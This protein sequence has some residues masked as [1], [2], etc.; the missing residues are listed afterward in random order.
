MT[1]ETEN[2]HYKQL[3]LYKASILIWKIVPPI[4]ILLGTIGNSLSILVLTRRS[5][6]VSST[7]LFLTVLAC[8]DL[9]VLYSGL[10]R[11]WLIYLFDTD[12][13]NLSEAGCKINVW[14][15]YSSLDFSAWILIV[16][17]LE[18]VVSTWMPHRARTLCTKKTAFAFII[19]VGV[20]ILGINSHILYGIGYKITQD[21][22]YYPIE[23]KCIEID[24]NYA[25]FFENV[26]PWIDLCVYCAVPFVV[27]VIGNALILF[28]VLNS[29]KKSK[30]TIASRLAKKSSMPAM[31]FTLNIVFLLSTLPV[32][33]YTIGQAY[34]PKDLD[35]YKMAKLDFW[36]AVVNMLMYTNN[37]LNF[38]LYCLS[39]TKFR[40][41]VIRL[42]TWK[43]CFR[44][45]H[46]N[47]AQ[48]NY[49]STRFDN[50]SRSSTA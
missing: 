31:L 50:Q 9:L 41:E 12:V 19:A 16:L 21:E 27:I 35:D 48:R 40:R 15:V 39:G 3:G 44:L 38:L 43:K 10:L 6:R 34:W 11:Q 23:N 37:S 46:I 29:Q 49:T 2:D 36:W 4:L 32:S 26:W 42:L 25:Y 28:K 24:R 45:N 14:L 17:T 30:S 47:P 7:A 13:R 1:N 22:N 18:R 33:I 20:F 8:S 5:I